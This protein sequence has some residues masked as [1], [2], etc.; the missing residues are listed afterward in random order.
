[1]PTFSPPKSNKAR[2]SVIS[3]LNARSNFGK[4]L[5]Q[6]AEERRSLIIERRG[7]PKAILLSIAEYVKLAAPEPEI[8]RIIGEESIRKGTDKLSDNE[9]DLIIQETRISKKR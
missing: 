6:V 8:L 4:I 1:M 9:I 3:A 2:A 7:R 5:D